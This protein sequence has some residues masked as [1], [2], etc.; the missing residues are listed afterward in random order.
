MNG[1]RKDLSDLDAVYDRL[2]NMDV[3]GWCPPEVRS[4]P[5]IREFVR[6]VVMTGNGALIYGNSFVEWVATEALRRARP[7]MLVAQ[8]GIR[9]RLKPFASVA[10]FEDQERASP[11]PPIDDLPGGAV[12][13]QMLALYVWLAALHHPE[14]IHQT[15]CLCIA[16]GLEEA[17]VVAP[18]DFP[19]WK[20]PEP[21]NSARLAQVVMTW[22]G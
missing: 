18:A 7:T 5:V 22:L 12:D 11:V 10:V 15:A 21:I 9:Q 4:Q 3:T 2:R 1:V 6:A 14:Y 13:A 8:F 20:E 16:E 19:I 17:Y